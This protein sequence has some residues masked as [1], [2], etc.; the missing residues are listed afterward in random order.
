VSLSFSNS[1]GTDIWLVYA[2]HDS[3]CGSGGDA[4]LKEGWWQIQPGG[5][6]TVTGGP[7]NGA[8]YFYYAEGDSGPTWEGEFTTSVP[9]E[10]F[11]QCWNIGTTDSQQVSMREIDVPITSF[12]H[13]VNL[14][15]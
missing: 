6:V 2:H 9:R 1:T 14:T 13:T 15:I 4:W 5:S 10:V 12:N 7:V 8:R 3:D 11:S